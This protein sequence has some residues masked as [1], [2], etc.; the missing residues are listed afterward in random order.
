MEQEVAHG[1]GGWNSRRPLKVSEEMP[2]MVHLYIEH[3]SA[4]LG[5]RMLTGAP[6]WMD[7]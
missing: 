3:D 6:E 2:S 1:Q 5:S 4:V 7:P